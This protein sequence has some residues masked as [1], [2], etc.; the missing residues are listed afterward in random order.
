MN[1]VTKEEFLD[2]FGDNLQSFQNHAGEKLYN[3][4][5]S[6][7][8]N[9]NLNYEILDKKEFEDSLLVII[10]KIESDTQKIGAP[11][12]TAAWFN[13]WK[14]NLDDFN[15]TQDLS[16]IV[17]KFIRPNFIVRYKQKLIKPENPNFERDVAILI[18]KYVFIKYAK[19]C[20]NIYEFGCGSS[21]NLVTLANQFPEKNIYGTDFV[22][23]AVDLVNNIA[24]KKS[25]NMK[26]YLFDMLNPDLTFRIKN[27]SCIF[28]FGAIEQLASNFGKF[29][30]YLLDNKPKICFHIEPT[31]EL[32]DETNLLDYLAMKFHRKRG[33]SEG[34]LP[35][36]QQLENE[37]KIKILNVRRL[38]FGS[39]FMEGYN[40]IVWKII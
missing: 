28:T 14:E 39:I 7:F 16:S 5:V 37:G 31:I 36:L 20:D 18:Q 25:F 1:K 6:F 10:K 40:L 8:D 33:Y 9:L 4:F 22:E 26:G 17:P 38:M 19:D 15:N 34:L 29:L 12:R 2:I 3:N 30:S 11:E 21:F 35:K 32:Y 23:S 27:N 13:G 24:K